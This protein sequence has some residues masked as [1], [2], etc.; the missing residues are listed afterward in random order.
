MAKILG[1][2]NLTRDSFSDGGH[3]LNPPAATAHA[4]QL[5]ADGADIIDVGA[6][7]THPDSE[8]VEPEEEIRR[9]APVLSDLR[10]RGARVSVDTCKPAVMRYA[11]AH[12]AEFINDVRGFREPGAVEAVRDAPAQLIVMHSRSPTA[13]AWREPP[14]PTSP[15]EIVA[16]IEAFFAERLATLAAAG[17]DRRRVILDPGMGFFLGSD[18]ELSLTTLGALPRLARLG[19]PLLVCTSRKS[20]LG[21]WLGTPRQ[22]RPIAERSAGTLATELWAALHGA[23]YLRT[24]DVRALR[25]ALRVVERLRR[26]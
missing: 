6:E 11:L 8:A 21:A 16:Q 18:P 13:R 14:L 9:L 25:D 4:A 23:A 3:Y 10:A 15:A 1:I 22:P 2:L 26:E 24:H 5:L 12:G 7:S 17:I 20:F 19:C